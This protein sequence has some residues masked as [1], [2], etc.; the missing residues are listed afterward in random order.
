ML[1]NSYVFICLF[2]PITLI[3]YFLLNKKRYLMGGKVWLTI[4]SL[5]F[6]SYS[7][8]RY[9]PLMLG[10]IVFNYIIG[11]RLAKMPVENKNRKLLLTFGVVSNVLLLGYYK[12]FNFFIEN[13]NYILPVDLKTFNIILPIGISFFTFTQIAFLVDNYKRKATEYD[14]LNYIL[15]VT[16]F[17]HL[18]AGPII[19]HKEMMPQ[20]DTLKNKIFNWKSVSL[21]IFL[22]G[23]G[24]FKKVVIADSISVYATSG[25]D[26]TQL[27]NFFEAWFTSISYTLQLYFDFSGYTDMALGLGLMFNIKLPSNFNSP[28]KSVSIQDFW[29]R[30][31]ITLSRFLRDYI[32]IPLGGNRKGEISTYWNLVLTFLIGGFWH[33]AGWTFIIWGLLHGIGSAIHKYWTKFGIK[34]NKFVAWFLTFNFI[35]V[36]WVFFRAKTVDSA[37]RVLKGMIGLNGVVLPYQLKDKLSFLSSDYF[38]PNWL[39]I[40]NGQTSKML[41]FV[42]AAFIIAVFFK[43]S[44]ELKLKFKPNFKVA[45]FIASITFYAMINM[46]KIQEFI[47]FNF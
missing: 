9:L 41:F 29:R 4:V 32:Y 12:Y 13:L 33:G 24:L 23:I 34:M 14:F 35:N 10:S 37:L 11:T 21:G 47:Y 38:S 43:N 26:G 2:L 6:Y 18:I 15:F 28:Y 25:F 8:M 39:S 17:P 27:L 19:H 30:W 16:F 44:E 20:F 22:F 40:S 1:F 31:H 45:L 3:V 36:C 46:N 7:T 42:F 5:V